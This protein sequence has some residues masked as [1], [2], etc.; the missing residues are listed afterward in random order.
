MAPIEITRVHAKRPAKRD[1]LMVVVEHPPHEEGDRPAVGHPE[2]LRHEVT[3]PVV[4]S[5]NQALQYLE[6]TAWM[7]AD[8]ASIH[9]LK[10]CLGDE[11]YRIVRTCDEMT[12]EQLATLIKTCRERLMGALDTPKES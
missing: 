5:A 1:V 10:M 11:G 9:L 8:T 6:D 4:F 2:P 7:T 12:A 3:C